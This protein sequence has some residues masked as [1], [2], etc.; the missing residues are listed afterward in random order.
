VFDEVYILLNSNTIM[1]SL[2]FMSECSDQSEV[3]SDMRQKPVI[4]HLYLTMNNLDN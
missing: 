2:H 4:F 3:L 1:K